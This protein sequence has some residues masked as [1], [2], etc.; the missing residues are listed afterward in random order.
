MAPVTEEDPA[1]YP[2][3]GIFELYLA[4]R[5]VQTTDEGSVFT[6]S[7][8]P[9]IELDSFTLRL[10]L[11]PRH[12]SSAETR[13]GFL[14]WLGYAMLFIEELR[15]DAGPLALEIGH[16]LILSGDPFGIVSTQTGSFDPIDSPLRI[17]L[18]LETG[19]FTQ[20]L[21][22]SDISFESPSGYLVY[23]GVLS[24]CRAGLGASLVAVIGQDGSR[25][26]ELYP[27]I[28]LSLQLADS[29][30]FSLSAMASTTAAV[31][32]SGSTGWGASLAMPLVWKNLN[33]NLGLAYTEGDIHYGQYLNG[34]DSRRANEKTLMFFTSLIW[35]ASPYSLVLDTQLPF[36]LAHGEPV[37]GEDFIS[38]EVA[39]ELGGISFTSGFRTMGLFS[40]PTEALEERSQFFVGLGYS[41]RAIS[42]SLSIYLDRKNAPQ[43]ALT[44]TMAGGQAFLARSGELGTSP[45]W[46]EFSLQTGYTYAP[47]SVITVMPRIS[48]DFSDDA[49]LSVR[50]PL[51]LS[52]ASGRLEIADSPTFGIGSQGSRE[53]TYRLMTDIFSL[54][55]EL[56][57]GSFNDPVYFLAERG[58]TRLGRLMG[59]WKSFTDDRLSLNFGF[60]IP[61]RASVNLFIGNLERPR[62]FSL[63]IAM[64][65]MGDIGLE[66]VAEN[67]LDIV[68]NE[69]DYR[70]VVIPQLSIR[71]HFAEYFT[72]GFYANTFIEFSPDGF[73]IHITSRDDLEF[74]AG[75]WIEASVGKLYFPLSAG[76]AAGRGKE[77][78]YDEM[79][80]RDAA[81]PL[82]EDSGDDEIRTYASAGL[83][84]RSDSLDLL[85]QYS[86]GSLADPAEDDTLRL[87]LSFRMNDFTVS[88]AFVRKN[89]ISCAG[90]FWSES[91]WL[92]EDCFWELKLEKSFGHLSFCAWLSARSTLE[93]DGQWFN[94][95]S[96]TSDGTSLAF[97]VSTALRF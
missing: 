38:L 47:D 97:G 95:L 12:I 37:R 50:L 80:L 23:N 48:F 61:S 26:T 69:E 85:I 6:I 44:A 27:E 49:R 94:A 56:T 42:T 34:Y 78:Y 87:K 64:R 74:A 89:L 70:A 76:V 88:T 31:S 63:E 8:Q 1:T 91:F 90:S 15:L 20:T 43:L 36:D 45:S 86:L 39:L 92:S 65:P 18:S 19:S 40:S 9:Q 66:I 13:E 17:R 55:D 83:G 46:L 72:L 35:D 25:K 71:Q 96:R 60:N 82:K 14:S 41:N 84:W 4:S 67:L 81:G 5:F 7:F 68:Y 53:L 2:E 33:F 58:Q 3:P 21:S 57:I 73:D 59:S 11:D 10:D 28:S 51:S 24:G 30:D 75:G 62:I 29:G 77:V 32:G 79:S 22:Y 16:R 54:V 93:E 52:T